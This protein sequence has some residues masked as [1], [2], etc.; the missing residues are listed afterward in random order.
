MISKA[1]I[2]FIRSLADK[3]SRNEHQCFVAEGRKIV[4]ELSASDFF[5]RNI[6]TTD[7]VAAAGSDNY[8]AVTAKE[9]E[10]ISML[11]SP[12]DYLAV[13]DIPSYRADY[14]ELQQ[15]LVLALDDVQDPGNV[16]TIIRIADWFGIKDILCSEATADCFNPKVVQATMGAL[17]RVK[18]HYC[19]LE[20]AIKAIGSPVYGTF[21]D[22]ESAYSS[23]L[24][25]Q[26]V[27]VM[28]NEGRGISDK[29]ARLVTKKI[30]IPPFPE[31]TATS[32][33]L[34]VSTATAIICSEFR[35]R[36]SIFCK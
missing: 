31:G 25:Q 17:L 33:S 9:M 11:K 20:T 35:R 7:H 10:R 27:I 34:N 22:G 36:V 14:E 12:S 18:V 4:E 6:Y 1:E 28:G 29:I 30:F 16:G 5:V 24:S 23:Q 3:R 2:N 21:L 15:R 26:G 19:N 13:V 32:E 8:V